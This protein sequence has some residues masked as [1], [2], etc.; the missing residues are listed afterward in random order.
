MGAP[1]AAG[2]LR[3]NIGARSAPW[4]TIIARLANQF[5]FTEA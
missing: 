4:L 3:K 5:A 1:C 2:S